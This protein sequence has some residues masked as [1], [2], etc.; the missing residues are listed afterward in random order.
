MTSSIDAYLA[1]AKTVYENKGEYTS[2]MIQQSNSINCCNNTAFCCNP[3]G[4]GSYS[5]SR[6]PKERVITWLV[7]GA[8]FAAIGSFFLLRSSLENQEE[9][10]TAKYNI[11]RGNQEAE[12]Q[13]NE[14]IKIQIL[15]AKNI[16]QIAYDKKNGLF[17]SELMMGIAVALIT[18]GC[19]AGL[20][21]MGCNDWEFYGTNFE[22]CKHLLAAGGILLVVSLVYYYIVYHNFNSKKSEFENAY[23]A[24]ENPEQH[25]YLLGPQPPSYTPQANAQVLSSQV[26]N[27][28]PNS[29]SNDNVQ[30]FHLNEAN[31]ALPSATAPIQQQQP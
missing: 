15:G 7:I 13:Q 9:A 11:D 30:V 1:N 24:I 14:L 17:R 23:K 12:N 19:I 29:N 4:Q 2:A 5:P 18:A 8:F 10:S 6:D 25:R 26:V 3:Y 22:L 16:H 28:V 21:A 27:V 31:S 20:W